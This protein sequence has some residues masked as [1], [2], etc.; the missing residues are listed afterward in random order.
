MLYD[1]APHLPCHDESDFPKLETMI[2]LSS[3]KL[4]FSGIFSQN[5]KNVAA[6]EAMLIPKCMFPRTLSKFG[7]TGKDMVWE[8]RGAEQNG[9]EGNIGN[10]MKKK[11]R[12]KRKGKLEGRR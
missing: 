6:C 12:G 10:K 3:L 4:I 1:Q 11:M 2:N 7:R 9:G 8:G 5:K